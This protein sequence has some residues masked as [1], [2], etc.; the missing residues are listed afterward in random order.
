MG[1]L[2]RI[3]GMSIK[4][5]LLLPI[6][7]CIV[8]SNLAY[9]VF[10]ASKHSSALL[11]A[12]DS[13][14]QLAQ[15]FVVPPVAAAVWDFNSDAAMGAIQGIAE[16]ENALFVQVI[17][18]GES[19]SEVFVDEAR[20]EEFSQ[21]ISGILEDEAADKTVEVNKVV[22]VKFPLNLADGTNVG[23]M[24]MGFNNGIIHT[25]ITSLYQQS[26]VIG[27]A[28]CLLIGVIVY[29]SAASVTRP[30]DRIVDRIDAL[31]SGDTESAVPE[32]SRGDELGRL[33]AAVVEFVDAMRANA[34][35][36]E[37]SKAAAEEQAGVVRELANGLNNLSKGNLS[38]R[39]KTEMSPEYTAL[40]SDFNQTAETLDDLIGRVLVTISQMEQ[41]IGE[42]ASGTDDLSQRTEN[43][44]ATLEETAAALDS[45]T[46]NVRSAT[47]QTQEVEGT[48]AETSK[49]AQRSGDIV[50]RTVQAMKEIDESSE[51]ISEINSVIDDISFQTSL[52]ALNA[53]V[54]AA[55]AG[56]V[57]RGFAVVASEVRSLA[58]KSATSA[59]EIR[60]LI[61]TSSEKVKVGVDLVDA[62]GRSLEEIIEKIQSV[63]TLITQI[64]AS[65]G[66]QAS[67]IS[68]IN[69]G[70]IE[71]DRVT[72]QNA[73]M[74]LK[75]SDQ[76]KSLQ[77]AAS[78]LAELV[79]GL[80][81]TSQGG[82][83]TAYDEAPQAMANDDVFGSDDF[84]IDDFAAQ[85]FD[86]DSFD[87]D[88]LAG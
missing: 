22:Y 33:A 66:E 45:I 17:V 51:K 75:S 12:F 79:A 9:T 59:N 10:W 27:F 43:Q 85:G 7:A 16:M 15:R 2:K 26:A 84:G 13:E 71:L 3:L 50:Q 25:T 46:S 8:L 57:G 19:F 63:S 24:V 82:A 42:M 14:V 87:A 41:Q 35:L 49:V 36:E 11:E 80:K 21:Q 76:G 1:Y 64:A 58:L 56:E 53:G 81:P 37:S 28:I 18:D 83:A 54:E 86:D 38:Y 4:K 39:I 30:L 47:T 74:V 48:I 5:K 31:R 23:Q 52:L 68:E 60:E 70:M 78:E 44:A 32:K 62:A 40:R 88:R 61:R 29:F 67:T 20:R 73:S 69:A 72:Q 65:S 77:Q 55:R 6:L 34:E